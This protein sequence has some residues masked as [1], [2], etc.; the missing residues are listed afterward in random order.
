ME[1]Q[2]EDLGILVMDE[3]SLLQLRRQDNL[4]T[5]EVFLN[6]T[7]IDFFELELS[8]TIKFM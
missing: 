5:G 6:L 1:V 4:T 7:L 2:Q 8:S 3:L